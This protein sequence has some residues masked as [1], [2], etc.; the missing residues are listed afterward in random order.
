[1]PN[2][3]QDAFGGHVVQV[4]IQENNIKRRTVNKV[5]GLKSRGC[6]RNTGNVVNLTAEMFN[7]IAN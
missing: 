7:Q 5:N 6:G 4:E 3:F 2:G 1:M